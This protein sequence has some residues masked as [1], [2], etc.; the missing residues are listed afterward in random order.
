MGRRVLTREER[1]WPKVDAEFGIHHKH[2][3]EI[4]SGR[5]WSSVA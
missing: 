3:N 1:F 2:V 4:A 5:S